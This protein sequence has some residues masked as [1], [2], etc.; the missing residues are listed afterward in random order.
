MIHSYVLGQVP[1]NMIIG[2]IR[3]SLYLPGMA[4]LWSGVSAAIA[5]VKTY[6]GLLAV[7]FFLGLVEAPLFPG[8]S[9]H[10]TSLHQIHMLIRDYYLYHRLSTSCR[11]GTHAEKL[12]SAL[13]LCLL[14]S[15]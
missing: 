6:E 11:V 13:P 12:R 3:P 14:E 2:K 9:S 15:L 8:V 5:G 10:D 1:S 7:R 4:I